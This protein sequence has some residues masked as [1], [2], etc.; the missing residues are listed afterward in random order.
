M[1]S[2]KDVCITEFD[3]ELAFI[4]RIPVI[5]SSKKATRHELSVMPEIKLANITQRTNLEKLFPLVV[6][7]TETTGLSFQKDEIIEISAIKYEVGFQAVSCYTSLTKPRGKISRSASEVN[8][9][10]DDMVKNAPPFSKIV[11][12]FQ[13]YI[14]GCNIVGHNLLFDLKFLHVAGINFTEKRKYFDTLDL[15]KKVLSAKG[16]KKFDHHKKKYVLVKNYDVENRKLDTLCEHYGIYRSISHRSLS[17]CLATG[18]LFGNL[19]A[20][21][22]SHSEESAA[23]MKK[24][25]T[26]S[27]TIGGF[28]AFLKS[29]F[30]SVKSL[31]QSLDNFFNLHSRH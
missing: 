29:L 31:F 18:K 24:T 27:W 30:L 17:D 16:E 22:L 8:H 13:K 28:F 5:I 15:S 14:T 21:K 3:S 10:T 4:P 26:A 1:A 9:I 25:K 19:V 2:Y 20:D 11:E 23:T 12:D 7:D 6:I